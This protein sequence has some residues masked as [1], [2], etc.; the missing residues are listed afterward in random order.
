[1]QDLDI[2]KKQVHH[3]I[4]WLCGRAIYGESRY[5]ESHAGFLF[6]FQLDELV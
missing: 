2:V 6:F 4:R 3:L 5:F 1:M